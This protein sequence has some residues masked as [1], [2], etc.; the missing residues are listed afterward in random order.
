ME[1]NST[2]I[3]NYHWVL[4]DIS[5]SEGN[6]FNGDRIADKNI[7]GTGFTLEV[8]NTLRNN[9]Q[10]Y[11]I[12]QIL[13]ETNHPD[14]DVYT[15][16]MYCY[17]TSNTGVI[18]GRTIEQM[19]HPSEATWG[20][21]RRNSES[22]INAFAKMN[23]LLIPGKTYSEGNGYRW[24]GDTVPPDEDIYGNQIQIY[25][26]NVIGHYNIATSASYG[27]DDIVTVGF[28]N[29]ILQGSTPGTSAIYITNS[30]LALAL[31]SY[32]RNSD[33][34]SKVSDLGYAKTS[35]L[36][37]YV[38]NTDFNNALNQKLTIPSGGTDGSF[39]IKNVETTN[40][41]T[42]V[43]YS[44]KDAFSFPFYAHKDI[45]DNA[46]L[47]DVEYW[48]PGVYN[49]TGI[50]SANTLK[51]FPLVNNG[52]GL[53]GIMYVTSLG[54]EGHSY[55]RQIYMP[56]DQY[57]VI[58]IRGGHYNKNNGTIEIMY[59]GSAGSTGGMDRTKS[60]WRVI[61]ML[62]YTGTVIQS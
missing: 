58:L 7:T 23:G 61:D 62:D 47:N 25:N 4:G 10:I 41:V 15:R 37:S 9:G 33:L 12:I 38:S 60:G 30:A 22:F 6:D 36:S 29:G 54:G 32:V 46:D 50:E 59:Y 57:S 55:R 45:P 42:S 2:D 18:E 56:R 1:K 11:S 3:N 20:E 39:I 51:N 43:S 26:D 16:T 21:W 31:N 14:Q 34:D 27:N 19:K 49:I 52:S 8:K 35:E 17:G 53:G 48:T 24:D 13:Y 5:D 28:L 40:G 44:W